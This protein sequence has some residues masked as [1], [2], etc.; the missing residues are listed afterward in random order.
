MSRVSLREAFNNPPN[1]LSVVF[2]V[3]R[4]D[5]GHFRVQGLK[6]KII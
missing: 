3:H 5:E 2:R 1:V 6:R 4:Q